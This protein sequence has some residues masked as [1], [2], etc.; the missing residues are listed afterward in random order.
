MKFNSKYNV[1]VSKD[2]MIYYV[3]NDKLVLRTQ[4]AQKRLYQV[5]N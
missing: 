5:S 3:K 4:N 1:Y 2:G